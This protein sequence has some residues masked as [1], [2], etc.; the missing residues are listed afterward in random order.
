MISNSTIFLQIP[1]RAISILYNNRKN[2][3]LIFSKFYLISVFCPISPPFIAAGHKTA[4][5]RYTR[6]FLVLH[7][8]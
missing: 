8:R 2:Y 5:S 6:Q 7:L 1:R 3:N 4:S